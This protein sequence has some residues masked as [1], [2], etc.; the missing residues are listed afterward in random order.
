MS[1]VKRAVL[2][3]TT[4]ALVF[5]SMP[6]APAG[7]GDNACWDVKRPERRFTR[8]INTA[9][10][11]ANLGKLSLDPELSKVARVHTREM[12]NADKL[13]HTASDKLAKRVTRWEILGE[14]VGVGGDVAGLHA[15]FMA[16]PAHAANVLHSKFRHVGVGVAKSDGRMWVTIIFEATQD[17]GTTLKMPSC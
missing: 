6:A 1:S 11:A 14:N 7:T 3:A 8:L 9:R 4:A 13:F 10:S 5:S 12:T 15:A 2:G 17:P 16:S